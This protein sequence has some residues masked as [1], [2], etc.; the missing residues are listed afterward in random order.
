MQLAK[1]IDANN[2]LGCMIA[3]MLNYPLTPNPDDIRL[4]DK[5]NLI[6][7][8]FCSDVMVKGYYPYYLHHYIEENEIQLEI[9]EGDEA[10]LRA[11]TVDF[12]ACSYYMSSCM[13]YDKTA[14]KVSGNLLTGLKNP[15]LVE[16]EFGWQIDPKGLEIFLHRVYD[17]YQIPIMIVENGLGAKDELVDGRVQDSYRI[18]YLR[19]HIQSLKQVIAE[20]VDLIGYLPWSALDVMALSTGTI[21]K[22]YGFIYVDVDSQGNGSLKRYRKDSFYWYQKVI[23]SNGKDL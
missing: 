3:S 1:K 17:R 8:M 16:S 21:D 4:T 15:Y 13:S 19:E 20:G 23:K 7:N 11:G 5:E 18:A 9:P 14:D 12:Y 10:I 22:R 2:Q 6:K